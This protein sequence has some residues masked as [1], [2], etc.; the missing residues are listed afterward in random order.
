MG[1]PTSDAA[2]WRERYALGMSPERWLRGWQTDPVAW[3]STWS[4]DVDLPAARLLREAA[5]APCVA[6]PVRQLRVH[7]DVSAL[8]AW[9]RDLAAEGT[10]V[11]RQPTWMGSCAETGTWA[12]L[13]ESNPER[14]DT[15]LMRL[16]ARMAE[17]AWLGMN[18]TDRL[19]V[20]ALPISPGEAIAWVEMSRGLLI[21]HVQI[22][23]WGTAARIAACQVVAP[24]EWNFH[25]EGAVAQAL[26]TLPLASTGAPTRTL[27][28]LMEAYDPCV[29]YQQEL[30]V[31]RE[32]A[33]A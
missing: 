4:R 5:Q 23:G 1:S 8:R 12:R 7:A 25:P 2:G 16:G 32:C 6:I 13:A 14:Y 26:E 20:G 3:L 10:A 11:A 28:I 27:E 29:P 19:A 9:A 31:P 21:H 17:V 22:E 33:H 18:D 24:T 15:P 30:S